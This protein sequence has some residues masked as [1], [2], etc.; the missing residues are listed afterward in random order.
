MNDTDTVKTPTLAEREV[1]F[2]AEH[3]AFALHFRC[4]HCAHVITSTLACS[5]RYPNPDLTGPVRGLQDNG[6]PTAC[7]YW[8]LSESA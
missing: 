4:E 5:M 3:A 6:I 1:R 8:E 2:A 7:K